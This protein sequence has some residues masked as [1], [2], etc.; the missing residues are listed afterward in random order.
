MR[1]RRKPPART[2]GLRVEGP[3]FYLWDLD[4]REAIRLAADLRRAPPRPGRRWAA[5]YIRV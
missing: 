3:G 5:S 4:S 2:R 1:L